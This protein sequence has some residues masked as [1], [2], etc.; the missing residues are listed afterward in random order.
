M[1]KLLSL[2]ANG[3]DKLNT[4]L[5]RIARSCIFLLIGILLFEVV[6]RYFFNK[7]TVWSTEMASMVFGFY[8]LIGGGY[9]LLKGGHVRMDILYA[10]WSERKRAIVDVCTFP[11]LAVYLIT[12][13]IGGFHV[14][15]YAL[16]FNQHSMSQWAPPLAPIEIVTV[17]G[18]FLLLLQGVAFFVRDLYMA[19]TGRRLP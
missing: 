11:L 2:F 16:K 14:V 5:G 4:W 19:I 7:P 8:F 1:V 6:S 13:I 10:N 17:V 18:A 3:V 9:T 12:F 15:G